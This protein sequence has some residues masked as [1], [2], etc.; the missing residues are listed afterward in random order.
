MCFY[1]PRAGGRLP[2]Y[3]LPRSSRL[4]FMEWARRVSSRKACR[5]KLGLP[6]KIFA[7]E[8]KGKR[9]GLRDSAALAQGHPLPSRRGS[10]ELCLALGQPIKQRSL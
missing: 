1:Q 6:G 4:P 2:E 5:W 3:Q 10:C 7:L 9:C 8:T